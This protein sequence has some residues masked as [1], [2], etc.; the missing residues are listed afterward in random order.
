MN[1]AIIPARGGSKRIP[2]KNIKMFAGRPL[3]TYAIKTA[4]DCGL[5]DHVVVST[6]FS[7]IAII[8]EG[9]GADVPFVRNANI[10]DDHATTEAV[11]EHA[12]E[13]FDSQGIAPEYLCCI[14]PAAA[15]VTANDLVDGLTALTA[16][17]ADGVVSVVEYAHPVQRALQID[18]AGCLEMIDGRYAAVR[19]ND[20][21]PAFHDAGQFYWLKLEA[22]KKTG[23]ILAAERTWPLR[24]PRDRVVDID[25]MEDWRLAEH[26]FIYN[27]GNVAE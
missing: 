19:T 6:D 11:L 2:G 9:A 14:Y 26:L 10:S 12:V 15:M 4:L 21:Q 7:E 13:W 27:K 22:F 25:T 17:D 16:N 24:L 3:I 18:D 1:V 23:Q 5:F 20:L 8:A